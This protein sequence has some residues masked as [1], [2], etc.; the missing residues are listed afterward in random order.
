M[1]TFISVILFYVC[2]HLILQSSCVTLRQVAPINF[3]VG[4][5]ASQ[6]HFSDSTYTTTLGQQYNLITAEY[7]CKWSATELSRGQ[8]D[9]SLCDAV[10][11]YAKQNNQTFRGHNLCWGIYNPTWLTNGGFSPAEKRSILQNH[12]TTVV[13]R[14]GD[15]VYGWDVVNEAV[16]DSGNDLYKNNT[17][18]P[19]IPD[20]VDFAFQT[21]RAANPNVKLFYNDYSIASATGWSAQKSQKV[22]DMVKSMKERGIPIDGV[23]IQLHVSLSYDI[24]SGIIQNLQRLAALGLEVHFTEVDVSCADYGQTCTSWTSDKEQQQLDLYVALLKACLS[25]SKC[26]NFE[27]WGFTDKY[28]WLTSSQHPLPY[29]ENYNPKPAYNG[30]LL[31]LES[32]NGLKKSL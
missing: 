17:W 24:V 11:N 9:F 28:T 30:I 8:F 5:A 7:E 12:I 26:R 31:T 13:K 22:Y 15:S 4:S 23:G 14:Y 21:A 19:D 32:V 20:Y 3:F 1:N 27:T 16:A 25:V 2:S 29:D 6:S 18:Y 10:Y